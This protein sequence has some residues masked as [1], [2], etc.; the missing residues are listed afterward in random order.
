MKLKNHP[1]LQEFLFGS[2]SKEINGTTSNKIYSMDII[3]NNHISFIEGKTMSEDW[4]FNATYLENVKTIHTTSANMFYYFKNPN[5][6]THTYNRKFVQSIIGF[7]EE[8]KTLSTKYQYNL[9]DNDLTLF[10]LKRWFGVI[11][12]EVLNPNKEEGY[13]QFK[14]YLSQEYFQTHLKQLPNSMLNKKEWAYKYLTLFHL[15]SLVY[16]IVYF[17]SKR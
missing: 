8:I 10:Y 14:R 3:N 12:N 11:S 6:V 5:S 13:K 9:D 4:M 17:I 2:L 1:G 16:Y 15:K 7:I